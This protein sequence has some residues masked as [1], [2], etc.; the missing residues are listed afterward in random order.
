MG[1]PYIGQLLLASWNFT[2]RGFAQCNGQLLNISGN[3]PL[4]SLLGTKYGGSGSQF[5]LPNLQGRTPV[6]FNQQYKQGLAGGSETIALNPSQFPVSSHTHQL[7]GTTTAAS[8]PIPSGN[9]FAATTGG[10]T[11]YAPAANLVPLNGGSISTTGGQPH[12]NRQPYLV[13]NW[14]IALTGIYPERS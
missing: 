3:Q 8:S 11:L 2:P 13:L 6:S 14:L 10:A 1:T 12:E 7:Q 5:A 9:A 4:F